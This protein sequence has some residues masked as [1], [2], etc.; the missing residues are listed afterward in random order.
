MG[1]EIGKGGPPKGGPGKGPGIHLMVVRKKQ[2]GGPGRGQ[3]GGPGRGQNVN[4]VISNRKNP[5]MK[6]AVMSPKKNPMLK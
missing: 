5:P 2:G 6:L 3:G 4:H 1:K